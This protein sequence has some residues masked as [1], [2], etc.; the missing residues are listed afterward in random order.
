MMQDWE[1]N[2][3]RDRRGRIKYDRDGKPTLKLEGRE[4][5]AAPI[6]SA[7]GFVLWLGHVCHLWRLR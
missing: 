5:I 7:I 1:P 2:W 6:L 4:W 3:K